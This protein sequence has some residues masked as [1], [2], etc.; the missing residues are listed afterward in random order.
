MFAA[1][2]H[3]KVVAVKKLNTRGMKSEH[4]DAFCSEAS[5]MWYDTL[6]RWYGTLKRVVW[7]FEEGG[8]VLL[9]GWYGTLKRVVW[10][11]EEGGMVL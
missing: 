3:N 5:L 6:K 11:F 2:L 7:Y 4:I 10:Y 9:R 8:M 1:K